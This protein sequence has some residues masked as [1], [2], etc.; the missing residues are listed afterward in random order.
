MACNSIQLANIARDCEAN[1]G[2]IKKVWLQF[3]ISYLKF[4]GMIRI[5]H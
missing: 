5:K 1:V 2:G 3:L 4:S